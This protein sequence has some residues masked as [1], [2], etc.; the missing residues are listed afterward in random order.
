MVVIILYLYG[1]NV[2]LV[3]FSLSVAFLLLMPAI[4]LVN[5]D[6]YY[7]YCYQG[8]LWGKSW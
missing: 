7:C 4:Y 6:Y 1:M 8:N 2:S 5:K 3:K